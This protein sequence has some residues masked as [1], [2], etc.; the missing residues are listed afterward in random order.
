MIDDGPLLKKSWNAA[1]MGVV[2]VA[3]ATFSQCITRALCE[4]MII[5]EQRSLY[6]AGA[7][8]NARYTFRLYANFNFKY[9]LGP[10][11]SYSQFSITYKHREWH[12]EGDTYSISCFMGC[13]VYSILLCKMPSEYYNLSWVVLCCLVWRP[14]QLRCHSLLVVKNCDR[15]KT[16]WLLFPECLFVCFR[17]IIETWQ[18]NQQQQRQRLKASY[19]HLIPK[20]KTKIYN[21]RTYRPRRRELLEQDYLF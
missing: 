7:F 6:T 20:V 10:W 11:Q 15:L 2:T 12:T 21:K 17:W 16:A 18:G 13:I 19:S 4:A 3:T 1:R 14:D 9:N 5:S 8:E